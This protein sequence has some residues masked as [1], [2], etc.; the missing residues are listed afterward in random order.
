MIKQAIRLLLLFG[1]LLALPVVVQA[2]QITDNFTTATNW[3]TVISQAGANLSVGSGRM[4]YTSAVTAT[5]G[6]AIP[7]N[8][9]LLPT[10]NDWSLKV[11]A[12]IDPFTLTTDGQFSDVFLGFGKTAD[13]VN[14]HVTF[15]FG[16]QLNG[17]HNGYYMQDDTRINGTNVAGLF[18]NWSVTSSN[19]ALRMDYSAANHT[20]TYYFDGDGAANGYNWVAQGTA[21]LASGTYNLNLGTSDTLTVLLNAAS[22]LQTVT[23]GQAYFTNLVIT[24]NQSPVVITGTG[25]ATSSS[26][27]T[28]S[29]TV[30]PNGLTTTAQ[31]EYGLTTN[32][33]KTASVTLT[34]SN[35][36]T[37]QALYSTITGLQPS[38]IYHWRLT[39]FNSSGVGVGSDATLVTPSEICVQEWVASTSIGGNFYDL[40]GYTTLGL[41]ISSNIT[42]MVEDQVFTFSPAG[43][44]I[45]GALYFTDIHTTT[46][47]M[48]SS[49]SVI[50][51]GNATSSGSGYE[52]VKYSNDGSAM[53]TNLYSGP[54]SHDGTLAAMTIDSSNN[55]IVTG[56][57]SGIGSSYDYTTIKYSSAGAPLWTNRY[58]GKGNAADSAVAVSVDN[59]NNVF[60][61]GNSVGSGA[62]SGIFDW[63]TIK[64]SSTGIPIWTNR[65][66][67]VANHNATAC[68]LVV[69]G[70]N[71]VI[72]GGYAW[73]GGNNY[74]FTTIKYSNAGAPLWTKQYAVGNLSDDYLS[75]M[76]VDS[77][78]NIIEV[79]Y[80]SNGNGYDYAT[81]KYSSS[82]TVLWKN[83]YH[84]Y[85]YYP[86]SS[87]PT[88]VAIDNNNNVIVT[89]TT[90]ASGHKY[91]DFLTIKYS[92][93][94]AT[95][96]TMDYNGGNTD[97]E[98]Y[99]VAVDQANNIFVAGIS[100]LITAHPGYTTTETS[101]TTVKYVVDGSLPVSFA[102]TTNNGT[103]TI[104]G[105]YA[106][107]GAM[108][109]P[110]T[111]NGLPV[112][113]I[114]DSAFAY[115]N[116]TG[117]KIPS[118]VT[119]IGNLVFYNC[120]N[121]TGIYFNGNAPAF[122]YN[123]FDGDNN[124]TVYYLPG[125]TGWNLWVSPPAAILWNPQVQ[126]KDAIFGVKTN[127]FGFNLTGS[128]NLV[129]VVEAS[130]DLTHWLP[131]QT[132][133]LTTGTAYFSD[134]QWT[135]YPGR[136]Y[137]LRSP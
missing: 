84:N 58:N 11:D 97:N 115:N 55:I 6:A 69:D 96:W 73:N 12:H 53:W 119:N 46:I 63:V 1:L 80:Y 92:G 28:V 83:T 74:V 94:G 112:T 123:V 8:T 78:N 68:S 126:T 57:S 59:S 130:T 71:N 31:F 103:I 9:P 127:R 14:T 76:S 43:L 19:V 42:L 108:T 121:L 34:P 102:Y 13:W 81:V 45:T 70:S 125:A 61:T 101:M 131:V 25:T 36:I 72:V 129:I 38:T 40:L 116:V 99:A 100:T 20:I 35:G 56:G 120:T 10:T 2:S 88:A 106:S 111:I 105:C 5:A 122:G 75:A 133:T 22:Q 29:G 49:N 64:Y 7:R 41:D 4:N 124:A 98:A 91:N 44:P 16:R 23:S 50:V 90:G 117:I 26:S 87:T 33:G 82:G 30:N 3:G 135:N 39:A 136:F 110:T 128:S 37:A 66:N 48:G 62:Y 15:E 52:V 104:T 132:N 89:G 137:R 51:A 27:A 77:N 67:S 79:G 54:A 109:I 18:A 118:S 134:P 32:Y 95:I 113:R 85:N 107:G 47:K 93:D 21:N 60:V 24:M 65:Y 86:S 114:A 17:S